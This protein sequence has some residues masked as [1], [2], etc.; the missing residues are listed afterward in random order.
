[1]TSSNSAKGHM[2]SMPHDI[3]KQGVMV[4]STSAVE[5]HSHNSDSNEHHSELSFGN[6]N[7]NEYN[8]QVTSS[9]NI[10][11]SGQPSHLPYT[12][13]SNGHVVALRHKNGAFYAAAPIPSSS[14]SSD[15]TQHPPTSTQYELRLLNTAPTTNQQQS[16][17]IPPE[18]CHLEVVVAEGG[19]WVGLR[20]AA[21]GGLFLQAKRHGAHKMIFY[22]SKLGTWEQW[23]VTPEHI[24]NLKDNDGN[25]TTTDNTAPPPPPRFLESSSFIDI[26][27]SNRRR[28][29]FKLNVDLVWMGR[30]SMSPVKNN[31]DKQQQHIETALVAA[32]ATTS[33]AH[34]PGQKEYYEDQ[35]LQRVS[36][37]LLSEWLAFVDN[38]KEVRLAQ[39]HHIE[40]AEKEGAALKKWALLQLKG[41]REEA[42]EGVEQLISAIKVKNQRLAEAKAHLET[43]VRWG[44]ALLMARRE[45]DVK[46]LVLA[47]WRARTARKKYCAKLEAKLEESAALQTKA[48]VMSAWEDRV[49]YM[50]ARQLKLRAAVRRMALL[51]TYQAFAAWRGFVLQRRAE[52]EYADRLTE[53]SSQHMMRWRTRH[54]LQLWR[55]SAQC[56]K[57]G[58]MML[59]GVGS[60]MDKELVRGV[61]GGWKADVQGKKAA[62]VHLESSVNLRHRQAL[63]RNVLVAWR[64]NTEDSF[65]EKMQVDQGRHVVTKISL[66]IAFASWRQ[67]AADIEIRRKHAEVMR[68]DHQRQLMTV[69]LSFWKEMHQLRQSQRE[70]V[71]QIMLVKA[72]QMQWQALAY[73]KYYVEEK[74][75]AR[76][77]VTKC[78][79]KVSIK[80]MSQAF[81]GW[82]T[83]VDEQRALENKETRAQK[84]YTKVQM[85][86]V[87]SKWRSNTAVSAAQDTKAL[88]M[89][90]IKKQRQLLST[91]FMALQAHAIKEQTYKEEFFLAMYWRAEMVQR[92]ALTSFRTVVK[93]KRQLEVDLRAIA[94]RIE[95]EQ[96]R[97]VLAAWN[98]TA[99]QSAT[100]NRLVKHVQQ[101]CA[102]R[103]LAAAFVGWSKS[104]Q[105]SK[106]CVTAKVLG[107]RK[108][109]HNRLIC[110]AYASWEVGA[111]TAK[112]AVEIAEHKG[113]MMQKRESLAVTFGAWQLAASSAVEQQRKVEHAKR[114][115]NK[116]M[117]GHVFASWR[118]GSAR[119]KLAAA[120]SMQ[121][122]E[123]RSIAVVRACLVGWKAH[124]VDLA[125]RRSRAEMIADQ[126]DFIMI[127]DVWDLWQAMVAHKEKRRW[128]L[129]L[130]ASKM[131]R[132]KSAL[133][134]KSWSTAVAAVRQAE[135]RA[136][137]TGAK[138]RAKNDKNALAMS[139]TGWRGMTE[140]LKL[141][142]SAMDAVNTAQSA[143]TLRL[144]FSSWSHSAKQGSMQRARVF[145]M[146]RSRQALKLTYTAMTAWTVAVGSEIHRRDVSNRAVK[147]LCQRTMSDAFAIWRETARARRARRTMMVRFMHRWNVHR[148]GVALVAW[149]SVVEDR[150]AAEEELRKCL[151]RKKV[152]FRTFKGWYWETFEH[153][154]QETLHNLFEITEAAAADP[155]PSSSSTRALNSPTDGHADVDCEEDE[156]RVEDLPTPGSPPDD[157]DVNGWNGG[158]G[159]SP[160]QQRHL[161]DQINA[162]LAS[163][164]AVYD[165]DGDE[166]DGPVVAAKLS[167]NND[168]GKMSSIAD[169]V[170]AALAEFL[171]SPTPA[172]LPPAVKRDVRGTT[173]GPLQSM[174]EQAMFGDGAA[175]AA[176]AAATVTTTPI[177]AKAMQINQDEEELY[178][179]AKTP[180][181]DL[182]KKLAAQRHV[183][184]ND[185][186]DYHHRQMMRVPDS[187]MG[188]FKAGG[189]GLAAGYYRRDSIGNLSTA[190]TPPGSQ[191]GSVGAP[192]PGSNIAYYPS[193]SGERNNN[194]GPMTGDSR[195]Y[196]TATT[197]GWSVVKPN[198]NRDIGV[199][200]RG[201]M[202]MMTAASA[203]STTPLGSSQYSSAAGADYKVRSLSGGLVEKR[204][205]ALEDA[206]TP[207]SVA[208]SS[209]A[210]SAARD[211][212]DFVLGAHRPGS[213]PPPMFA[214]SSVHTNPLSMMSP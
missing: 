128:Q 157:D 182:F 193:D 7:M 23:R 62:A 51:K 45:A 61:L 183:L 116:V 10:N 129:A 178:S 84:R 57:Q 1:M 104:A 93:K 120:R 127:G 26:E 121:L 126:R 198:M 94:G 107:L 146:F 3:S 117:M 174:F 20:S 89:V 200:G 186:G 9:S 103:R 194:G 177:A 130:A 98:S 42:E 54:A 162:K 48:A 17:A 32:N 24:L 176:A 110:Q 153:D 187:T 192:T 63:L 30:P 75:R 160:I 90:C 180:G 179:N 163:L 106:V 115:V 143:T 41:L 185:D 39:Q 102:Q 82:K 4:Q 43:R 80:L 172:G 135:W 71:K 147:R 142:R 91:I 209:M 159:L 206:S 88:E 92:R 105:H 118:D 33:T 66:K 165:N 69:G 55:K 205:L 195:M 96:A 141:A 164:E 154:L 119:A 212:G 196:A 201:M 29:E 208:G 11:T 191:A 27:L 28:P 158:Y 109:Y 13:L 8:I 101:R 173:L 175:A 99:A 131:A 36:G 78:L 133:A 210:F 35:V 18:E 156:Q 31:K 189:G 49:M 151:I 113:M 161:S 204:R 136:E 60:R 155:L 65:G 14:I 59:N 114:M 5:T 111:D 85:K 122:T 47:A 16:A 19:E 139:F 86:R 87:F 207:G 37:A 53:A 64:R 97:Q 123:N 15:A 46:R 100:E 134:I 211:R 81:T 138:I 170:E 168:K 152:A 202:N 34:T 125:S 184:N 108:R 188:Q 213:S 73:W 67:H 150:K 137:V 83:H 132:I 140:R 44:V 95:V 25:E 197:P 124:C 70:A 166:N 77:I 167:N 171:P 38:E 79:N 144:V 22:S 149:K 214:S 40:T 76:A 52:K 112:N 145:D 199:G 56:A 148:Q 169:K 72:E 181:S 2:A 12:H 203:A 190:T 74:K 68:A 21:S 50:Q 58:R 6:P